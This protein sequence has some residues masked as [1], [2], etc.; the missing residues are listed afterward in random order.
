[1]H[2]MQV[3]DSLRLDDNHFRDKQIDPEIVP[4][5]LAFVADVDP[6]F[7]AERKAAGGQLDR[8]AVAIYRFEQAWT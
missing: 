5:F 2:R 4:H 8:E 3:V 1:M 6:M 7:S